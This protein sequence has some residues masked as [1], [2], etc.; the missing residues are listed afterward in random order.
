[1]RITRNLDEPLAGRHVL[2]VDT[3]LDTGLTFQ[4]LDVAL[5]TRGP[6]SL[7]YC[8]PLGKDRGGEPPFPVD[9]VGFTIGD[10]FVVEYGLDYAQRYRNLPY[11]GVLRPSVYQR[12]ET[13]GLPD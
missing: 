7:R 11:I 13:D 12:R 5:R 9:Y 1:M 10:Q 2:V 6:A 4:A 8:V 3:V